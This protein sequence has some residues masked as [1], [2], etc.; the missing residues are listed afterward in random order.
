MLTS[1]PNR[2]SCF[3]RLEI[4]FNRSRRFGTSLSLLM[5]DIDHFK[6]F[7]DTY[8]HQVGDEALRAV[9]AALAGA[10]RSYDCAGRYGGE[11]FICFLPETTL[12]EALLVAERLRECVSATRVAAVNRD[13]GSEDVGMTVS[14]GIATWPDCPAERLDDL[15]A[16]ADRALYQAKSEGRNRCVVSAPL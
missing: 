12:A 11:E 4:E 3:T 10:I 2:R 1:L 6:N 7:N 15:V 8:G 9:G 5:L 16:A 13:G 14:V